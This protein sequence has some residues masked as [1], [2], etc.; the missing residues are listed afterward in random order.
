MKVKIIKSC[1]FSF[2]PCDGISVFKLGEIHDLPEYKAKRLI[3]C[4][5]A[6]FP[7][8]EQ[9]MDNTEKENKMFKVKHKEDKADKTKDS[10]KKVKVKH[11]PK[12]KKTKKTR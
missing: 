7:K 11:E 5:Y 10:E 9:K 8:F 12:V 1:K 6:I 3:E 4:N 2:R